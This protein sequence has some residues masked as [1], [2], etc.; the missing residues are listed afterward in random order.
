MTPSIHGI[1]G[2]YDEVTGMSLLTARG[3]E[4]ARDSTLAE[5]FSLA[6]QQ[7]G[8]VEISEV[9]DYCRLEAWLGAHIPK[10]RLVAFEIRT[11]HDTIPDFS[12]GDQLTQGCRFLRVDPDFPKCPADLVEPARQALADSRIQE[13]AAEL[14]DSLTELV[15]KVTGLALHYQRV[16]ILLYEEG[17]YISPHADTHSGTRVNVQFPVTFGAHS[18]IR[19][20]EDG[21]LTL[22]PDRPG[23]MRM[24]GPTVW[25]EVPPVFRKADCESCVRLNLTLRFSS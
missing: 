22:L 17:H 5:T 19:I 4:L 3:R 2:T 23:V 14:G 7:V 20:L 9:A 1:P 8:F 18:G 10:L 11:Q 13:I 21:N 16:S 12:R 15:R 6:Y 24:L 25:H